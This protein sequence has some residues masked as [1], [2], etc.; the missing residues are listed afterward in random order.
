MGNFMLESVYSEHDGKGRPILVDLGYI[1]QGGKVVSDVDAR[2]Q[3]ILATGLARKNFQVVANGRLFVKLPPKKAPSL[4]SR[5]PIAEGET[6][7]MATH[8]W[9]GLAQ[10]EAPAPV[11]EFD[12]TAAS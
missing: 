4:L 3:A 7:W 8:H 9:I 2:A 12:E 11:P 10:G 5:F 1:V 6:Y